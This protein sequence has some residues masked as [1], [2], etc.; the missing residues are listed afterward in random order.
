MKRCIFPLLLLLLCI[1]E[2][3]AFSQAPGVLT[4]NSAFNPTSFAAEMRG[5]R[6]SLKKKTSPVE[7]GSFRDA[8]PPNWTV[9]TSERNYSVSS[10]PLRDQLTPASREKAL[11]WMDRVAEEIDHAA[12]VPPPALS[13]ARAELDRVLAQSQFAAVR[14]PSRWEL[15]RQ[16]VEAWLERMLEKLFR[17]IGRHPIAGEFLFWIIVVGSVVGIALLLFRYLIS[18]DRLDSLEPS[19]WVVNTRTWQEWIHFARKAAERGDFR[20]AV[21][22]A[23]WAGIVRLEDTGVVP[24]DRSKTP[25]EYLRSVADPQA[26]EFLS[27]PTYREP[28]AALTSR[29]E[30]VWYANRGAGPEDFQESLR[31]LEALGCQLE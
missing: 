8:L 1:A 21:H 31:Q 4:T 25:R 24:K 11:L 13:N 29:L 19:A 2:P 17:G 9:T 12:L 26:G 7:I 18:R 28:L 30:S 3:A 6:A 22:S 14:P 15:F 23:Y 10:Q 16:R 5:L 27:R 20:E